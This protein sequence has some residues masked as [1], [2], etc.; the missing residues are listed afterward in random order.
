MLESISYKYEA[1]QDTRSKPRLPHQAIFVF[2]GWSGKNFFP[3]PI[4]HS[5]RIDFFTNRTFSVP[6]QT[7]LYRYAEKK[8]VPPK[9]IRFAKSTIRY[10]TRKSRCAYCIEQNN[11]KK[12]LKRFV[13]NKYGRSI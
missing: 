3:N 5:T 8:F 12:F 13:A 4:Q 11:K 7:M 10:G 6:Y 1:T 9:N 2:G